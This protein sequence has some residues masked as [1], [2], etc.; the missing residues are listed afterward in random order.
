[1]DNGHH[2]LNAAS[3]LLGITLLIIAGLHI[4]NSADKTLADEVAWLATLCF[5]VSSLLSYLSVRSGQA[6]RHC[7][8]AA[9]KVFLGG[10]VSLLAAVAILAASN[11]N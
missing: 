6:G 1:M 7:E 8:N 9:D 2:I 3:N 10:L 5:S 11:L 4:S